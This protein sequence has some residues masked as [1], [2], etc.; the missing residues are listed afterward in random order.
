MIRLLNATRT[1]LST[2]PYAHSSQ[3]SSTEGR[4]WNKKAPSL[5]SGTRKVW[6]SLKVKKRAFLISANGQSSCAEVLL[7]TSLS[8][9]SEWHRYRQLHALTCIV[10]LLSVWLMSG[11]YAEL[12][13]YSPHV[14][15]PGISQPFFSSLQ[16]EDR[17][18]RTRR[19]GR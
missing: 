4:T 12:L 17:S 13:Y 14:V 8:F 2:L 5:R 16:P 19:Y 3:A 6:V 10:R 11:E 1:P 18:T 15:M 7:T 9:L